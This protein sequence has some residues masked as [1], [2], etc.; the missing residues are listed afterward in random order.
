MRGSLY[1]NQLEYSEIKF[2][3]YNYLNACIIDPARNN[4]TIPPKMKGNKSVSWQSL[5]YFTR[6]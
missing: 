5:L 3:K 2:E 6:Y 1:F 4:K